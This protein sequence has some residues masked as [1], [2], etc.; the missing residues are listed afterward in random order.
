MYDIGEQEDKSE[1]FIVYLAPPAVQLNQVTLP[2]LLRQP[3]NDAGVAVA[4][5][6]GR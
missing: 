6:R 4:V 3:L 2:L 1:L 5:K